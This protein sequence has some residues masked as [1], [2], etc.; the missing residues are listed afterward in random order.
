[1]SS[2]TLFNVGTGLQDSAQRL[3]CDLESI[4]SRLRG[5]TPEQACNAGPIASGVFGPLE[6]V[7]LAM[8]RAQSCAAEISQIVGD[9]CH[10]P[11]SPSVLT[12]KQYR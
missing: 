9:D 11:T 5:P 4:L 3:A 2:V 8:Q 6:R 10:T 12:P 1:M 7:A